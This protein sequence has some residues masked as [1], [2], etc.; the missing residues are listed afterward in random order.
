MHALAAVQVVRMYERLG[1]DSDPSGIKGLAFRRN[2]ASG[3]YLM[4]REARPTR[5]ISIV[6]DSSCDRADRDS[7]QP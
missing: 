7:A 3:A 4:E 2:A 1:F 6:R 5:Y